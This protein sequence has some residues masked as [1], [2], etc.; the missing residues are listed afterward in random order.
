[1][2][3][4]PEV[5][6]GQTGSLQITVVQQVAN[7]LATQFDTLDAALD[8]LFFK[9]NTQQGKVTRAMLKDFLLNQ[10]CVKLT[11]RDIDLM[12][13]SNEIMAQNEVLT[14]ADLNA[15]LRKYFNDAI[16]QNRSDNNSLR[17]S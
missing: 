17:G 14:R 5:N 12:F 9:D 1:M 16:D 11:E 13:K 6:V 15:A 8:T 10:V 2:K 3:D 4:A 7:H